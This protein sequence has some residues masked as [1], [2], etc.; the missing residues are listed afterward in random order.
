MDADKWGR[1]A[2]PFEPR[3]VRFRP[4]VVQGNRALAM[5]YVDARTVMDR[6]DE[7]L[8]VAGWQDEYLVLPDGCVVCTLRC[9]IGL[10]GEWVS[11]SDVGGQSEQPAA[12]D[13]RKAAFSEA[14][15][16]AAVKFGVGRYLY[17]LPQQWCDYDPDRRR[18][19]KKPGLPPDPAPRKAAPPADPAEV[20]SDE[21]ARELAALLDEAR[22]D[23]GRFCSHFGVEEPQS[24]PATMYAEAVRL[25]K[26]Q[27]ARRRVEKAALSAPTD[28]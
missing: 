18:F 24:L 23:R 21:Q 25:L 14:I 28:N 11:K 5:P 16:R 7:V 8:G 17:R 27:A 4:G 20:I 19:L 3:E 6:V 2:T 26:G 22:A 9:R 15:K 10:E 13:R 1:L 12:G